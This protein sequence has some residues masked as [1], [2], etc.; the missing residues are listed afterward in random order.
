MLNEWKSAIAAADLADWVT[1]GAYLIAVLACTQAS[2]FAWLT[3]RERDRSFWRLTAVLLIFLGINEI[4]DLQALLT[5]LGREH[6]RANGWYGQHR[7]VQYIFILA[8][9]LLGV[10]AGIVTLFLTRKAHT[11]VRVALIGLGFI[12]L[13]VIVRAASFHHL[14][15]L[16]GRKAP[17]FNWGSMQE[18]FGIAIVAT[19]A[20]TYPRIRRSRR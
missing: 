2:R 11:S 18:L 17:L 10:L 1:V 4:L 13:F 19:A 6:A 9:A 14:D 16:L 15:E 7:P 8:L 5:V 20:L 3:R 12:G